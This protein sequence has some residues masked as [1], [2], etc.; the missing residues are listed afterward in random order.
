MIDIALNGLVAAFIFM[1][2]LFVL[3]ATALITL[4][5]S[6]VKRDENRGVTKQGVYNYFLS[7]LILLIINAVII[8]FINIG[9]KKTLTA[10]QAKSLDWWMLYVW[11]P[12]HLVNFFLIAFVL[13]YIRSHKDEIN[14]K[15][16]KWR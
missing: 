3:G 15:L 10:E 9:G 2:T 12:A 11:I 5:V 4:I 14:T 7:A 16:D 1:A 13:K 8:V 6:F